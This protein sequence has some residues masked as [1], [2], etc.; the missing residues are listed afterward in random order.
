MIRGGGDTMT[1]RQGVGE[2]G[3]WAREVHLHLL[4]LHLY[5]V[6]PLKTLIQRQSLGRVRSI[7]VGGRGAL[8]IVTTRWRHLPG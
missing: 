7:A 4:L 8:V 6:L 2:G 5:A 3:R 1:R